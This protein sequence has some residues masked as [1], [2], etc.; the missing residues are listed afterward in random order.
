M[1]KG[2]IS[3]IFCLLAITSIDAQNYRAVYPDRIAMYSNGYSIAGLRID[4]TG[5]DRDSF[6]IPNHIIRELEDYCFTPNGA[7]WIGEKITE[8]SNGFTCFINFLHDSVKL[9]TDAVINESWIMYKTDTALYRA[10]VTARDTMNFLGITDSIKKISIQVTDPLGNTLV[11]ELNNDYLL[12]SKHYGLIRTFHLYFFP[13]LLAENNN[14]Y[15]TIRTLA[16][17]D[18][19]KLGIQNILW[20]DIND[21][22][23][24]DILHIESTSDVEAAFLS[25]KD[26]LKTI[27]HY[28][29]RQNLNDSTIYTVEIT[30][31]STRNDTVTFYSHDTITEI[32]RPDPL[33]DKLP[34]E[35]IITDVGYSC[36]MTTDSKIFPPMDQFLMGNDNCWTYILADGCFPE[37]RYIKGLGGPYGACTSGFGGLVSYETK[38]VYYK[39]GSTTWGTPLVITTA[40]DKPETGKME[41][42]PNPAKNILYVK[43]NDPRYVNYS[44]SILNLQGQ[45][46]YRNDHYSEGSPVDV[47]GWKGVYV[48]KTKTPAGEGLRKVLVE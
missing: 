16:G 15:I 35:P 11:N 39:K 37:Q 32:F 40:D 10:T 22:Q 3:L 34:D 9:K 47:R 18:K 31:Q 43:L 29:S 48:I 45:V 2:I 20:S 41:V 21:F 25:Y 23:P 33:F 14:R 8:S 19:P 36:W 4:S 30:T 12:L 38:L 17:I 7:S 27:K 46:I 28:L 5:W 13:E 44:L 42:F 1:L 6:F 26:K 24:G